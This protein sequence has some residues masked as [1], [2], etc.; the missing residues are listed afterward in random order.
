MNAAR[1][2][3]DA[4]A[5]GHAGQP[6]RGVHLADAAAHAAVGADGVAQQK[7]HHRPGIARAVAVGAQ[8]IIDEPEAFGAVVIVGVDDRKGRIADGLLCRQDRVGR[9]PGLD[10]A[11]RHREAF[12]QFFKLLVGIAHVEPG[13]AGAL[14]YR[15]LE[16]VLDLVLDD[17][18][19]RLKPGAA[20]VVQAVIQNC[21]PRRSHRVDLL[22]AAV[23]AAHTGRHNDQD[24]F[25]CHNMLLP[26]PFALKRA[27]TGACGI[28]RTGRFV[29]PC[30][31]L[32]PRPFCIIS[33][34]HAA[35]VSCKPRCRRPAGKFAEMLQ[36]SQ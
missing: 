12:G 20:G 31:P 22:Q 18:D 8:E 27:G 28:R 5:L 36:D 10:A 33:M 24:R 16:S 32:G 19:H 17:K 11:L 4:G 3:F 21:L 9:A 14:P 1:I 25:V 13:A 29:R 35:A 23:A 34:I 15:R 7:A 6:P 26:V 2:R 30:F